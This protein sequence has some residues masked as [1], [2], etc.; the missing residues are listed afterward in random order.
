MKKQHTK[1]SHGWIPVSL[2]VMFT[3]AL[4]VGQARANLPNE[5]KAAPMPVAA[6][7]I[8]IVLNA[9]MM[10]KLESLS[11]LTDTLLA[12]PFDLELTIDGETLSPDEFDWRQPDHSPAKAQ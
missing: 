2:L 9:D 11:L 12:L 4:I 8:N 10:Q 3:I 5:V 1:V 7:S 6:T